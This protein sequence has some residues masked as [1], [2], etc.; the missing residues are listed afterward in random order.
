MCNWL[1]AMH[2]TR[3]S[4]YLLFNSVTHTLYYDADGNGRGTAVPICKVVGVESLSAAD[5]SFAGL[6]P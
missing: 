3:S 5:I 6:V 4:A 1:L 2:V